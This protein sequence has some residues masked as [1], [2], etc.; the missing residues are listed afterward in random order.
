MI[1]LSLRLRGINVDILAQDGLLKP[2]LAQLLDRIS[3]KPV[4]AHI[5][6]SQMKKKFKKFLISRGYI[7][8]K[9]HKIKNLFGSDFEFCVISLLV[10]LKY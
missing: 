10:M 5:K 8:L 7:S 4:L 2:F 3:E 6:G 1:P 9:V